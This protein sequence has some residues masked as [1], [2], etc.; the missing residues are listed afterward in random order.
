MDRMHLSDALEL[1]EAEVD[2]L[3]PEVVLLEPERLS[4]VLPDPISMG[5]AGPP[6]S[7]GV[8]KTNALHASRKPLAGLGAV[9]EDANGGRG[10]GAGCALDHIF[11]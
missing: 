4:T 8:S 2:M 5:L 1:L 9:W 7:S 6:Q 10:R 11:E 3:E